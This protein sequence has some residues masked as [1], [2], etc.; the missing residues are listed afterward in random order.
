[1]ISLKEHMEINRVVK[2]MEGE[3][4]QFT[5]EQLQAAESYALKWNPVSGNTILCL[6]DAADLSLGNMEFEDAD[7][8][9]AFVEEYFDLEDDDLA[10]LESYDWANDNYDDRMLNALGDDGTSV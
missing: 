4:P 6:Y 5:D 2:L 7:V 10:D 3:S 1:M 8:A 9:I